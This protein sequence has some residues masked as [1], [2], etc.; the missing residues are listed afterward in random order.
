MALYPLTMGTALVYFGE[1]YV[2]DL[3]AGA[4]LALVVAGL[5]RVYERLRG[6]HPDGSAGGATTVT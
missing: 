5:V 4:G 2:V 3:L 6:L 1:H